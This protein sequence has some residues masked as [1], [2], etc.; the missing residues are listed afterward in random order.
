[1]AFKE[2]EYEKFTDMVS[3]LTL[4]LI[5]KKPSFAHVEYGFKEEY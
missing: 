5:F 4:Q 3:D 1:M 2:T